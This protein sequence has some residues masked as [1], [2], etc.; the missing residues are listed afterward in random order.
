MLEVGGDAA[1]AREALAETG[2]GRQGG[3]NELEGDATVHAD[4][5]GRV[6]DPHATSAGN[7]QH[8]VAGEN[9]P[10]HELVAA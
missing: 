4:V 9:I 10:G 2:V 8:T 1:L 3:S 7:P 6:D 5:F